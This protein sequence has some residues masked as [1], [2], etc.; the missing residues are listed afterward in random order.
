MICGF[1]FE[2]KYGE[3]E[4]VAVMLR[5]KRN[6]LSKYLCQHLEQYL[7]Y[8]KFKFIT[9]MRTKGFDIPS[10]DIQIGAHCCSY[11]NLD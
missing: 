8:N 3:L 9:E 11:A 6:E 2:Q 10:S 7:E 4:D 5:N 1:D